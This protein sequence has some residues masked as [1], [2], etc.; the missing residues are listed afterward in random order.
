MREDI[1]TEAEGETDTLSNLGPLGP[2]AGIWEGSGV[3]DEHPV[4]EGTE[5]DVFVER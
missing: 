3:A 4:A 5:R 2:M 1:D